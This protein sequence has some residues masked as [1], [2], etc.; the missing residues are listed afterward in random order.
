MTERARVQ[1]A[2]G[3]SLNVNCWAGS[4]PSFVLVHGLASNARMWDG[5]AEVLAAAGARVAAVD[6]RGHGQSDKPDWGYDFGTVVADLVAVI[7]ALDLGLPVVAGQS[8]GGNLVL[9]LAVRAPGVARA[10][11]C[12]DGGWIELSRQFPDWEACRDALAPPKLAGTPVTEFEAGVRRRCQGWP[13]SGIQ[14]ML[15]NFEVRADGTVAPWLAFERHM[16]ILRALWEHKP[17]SLYGRVDVPAL[18]IPAGDKAEANQ[19]AASMPLGRVVVVEGDHDLHAQ[20]PGRV[21]ELLL[22]LA[23]ESGS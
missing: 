16:A 2:S 1:V 13:E 7:R 20:H 22:E 3:V 17:S 14:G 21:A 9:E 4:G 5:A 10:V 6:L 11:A 19:A 23:A 15:A 12:V 8:W 18:L